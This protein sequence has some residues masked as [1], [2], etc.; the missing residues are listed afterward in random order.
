MTERKKTIIDD[1]KRL[2]RFQIV[3]GL[4][5][6]AFIIYVSWAVR[7]VPNKYE[8]CFKNA[9]CVGE[10]KDDKCCVT[11]LLYTAETE[12]V[13]RKGLGNGMIMLG[14]LITSAFIYSFIANLLTGRE[15]NEQEAI[16][17]IEDNII[18]KQKKKILPQGKYIV[19]RSTRKRSDLDKK[20]PIKWTI[21]VEIFP[22]EGADEYFHGEVSPYW[23]SNK[24]EDHIIGSMPRDTPLTN[25]ITNKEEMADIK[26]VMKPEVAREIRYDKLSGKTKS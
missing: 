5:L 9:T 26:W 23:K 11:K 1:L 6:I 4:S 2:N 22:D 17:I 3:S 7:I 12:N 14:I 13:P 20:E 19:G 10:V 15:I 18:Y 25:L 24:K 8:D 16:D 21:S